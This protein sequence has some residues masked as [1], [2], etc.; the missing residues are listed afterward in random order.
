VVQ[1]HSSCLGVA[2]PLGSA[3]APRPDQVHVLVVPDR[4][5]G[6]DPEDQPA[7]D[8][9]FSFRERMRP[10]VVDIPRPAAATPL[11]RPVC[12][13]IDAAPVLARAARCAVWVEIRHD[14]NVAPCP[15]SLELVGDRNASEFVAVDRAHDEYTGTAAAA[16]T[17]RDN[18]AA[19]LGMTQDHASGGTAP[20]CGQ[21]RSAGLT[22]R[23][24]RRRVADGHAGR[25]AADNR[26]ARDHRYQHS[27]ARGD[28][29]RHQN[30]L[31][32]GPAGPSAASPRG[33]PSA[34]KTKATLS[35]P[36]PT[37]RR[38]STSAPGVAGR[39]NRAV[40]TAAPRWTTVAAFDRIRVCAPSLRQ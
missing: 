31:A 17:N 37:D 30:T 20:T 5:A 2:A 6:P 8:L 40:C 18:R 35:A 29:A 27:R 11:R 33:A 26:A 15:N 3:R 12:V 4:D 24:G 34:L 1:P 39:A 25:V 19:T 28:D 23:R 21:G 16:G 36:A 32:P 14:P 38:R 9:R 10:G 7:R 13:Q 22:P